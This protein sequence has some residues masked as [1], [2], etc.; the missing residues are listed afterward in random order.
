MQV[1]PVPEGRTSGDLFGNYHGELLVN[2]IDGACVAVTARN[3]IRLE[4]GDQVL[5]TDREPFKIDGAP[6]TAG[7]VQLVWM[8]GPNPCRACWENAESFFEG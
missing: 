3:R 2:C 5:F 6:D 8:P 1:L 7:V 4:Q